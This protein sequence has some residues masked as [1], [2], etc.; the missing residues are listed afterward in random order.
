MK[1]AEWKKCFISVVSSTETR[2]NDKLAVVFEPA[3]LDA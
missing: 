3:D 2:K 1:L